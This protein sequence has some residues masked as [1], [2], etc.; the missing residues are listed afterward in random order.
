[1]K[2]TFT[3]EIPV[4]IFIGLNS[5][6]V[7]AEISFTATPYDPGISSGPPVICYPPEGGEIDDREVTALY[8]ASAPD[9]QG[10]KLPADAVLAKPIKKVLECPAWL[11]EM[12]LENTSDDTLFEAAYF[13]DDY[14]EYEVGE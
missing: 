8:L 9:A 11:S 2:K 4:Q 3:H 5:I 14:W 10:V 13:D 12:I 6:E 1:M 7:M